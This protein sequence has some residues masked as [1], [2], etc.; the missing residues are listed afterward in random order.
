MRTKVIKWGNSLGLRI[1]KSFAEEVPV[2]DGTLVDLS[3]EEGQLVMRPA[4]QPGFDLEGLLAGVTDDNLH[5]DVDT[6]DPVGG[7]SW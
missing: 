3:I 5:G 4:P 6:G 7:E 2:S 1:P